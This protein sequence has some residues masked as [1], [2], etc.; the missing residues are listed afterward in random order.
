MTKTNTPTPKRR[1]EGVAKLTVNPF[2]DA[3]FYARMRDYTERDAAI[4]KELKA[5]AEIR[6]G[7][8]QPDPRL[9]P[10]LAAL[11]STV[12]KGLTF[13]EMLDRIAAGKEKGLWEP[14]MTTFGIEI[15]AVN[16]GAGPRNACLVLD[17]AAN[18]PAHAMFAKAG[19][20]NWRSLA[21]DDCSVVRSEK[22]TETSPLKV[23]AVFYLDPLPA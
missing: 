10:S 17:L 5:I 13:G 20:Q 2:L 21:A 14:W 8:K 22:A 12:K 4:I 18:A 1:E 6:A 7:N 23:Y 3:E 15:R 16:Y 19:I 9:A 11:R